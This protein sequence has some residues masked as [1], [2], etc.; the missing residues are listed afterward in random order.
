MADIKD[1]LDRIDSTG[2]LL[3]QD[4]TRENVV[5]IVTGETLS[6]SWW[7]HPKA[8]FV[9][10]ILESV[11]KH[12]DIT[13]SKLIQGKVTFIH[14][15]LWPSIY[16]VGSSKE[17]WQLRTLTQDERRLLKRIE[18]KGMV[19]NPGSTVK[20][21]ER[22]VL[23]HVAQVHS[24][25]GKHITIATSWDNWADKHQIAKVPGK[26]AKRQLVESTIQIK[27]RKEDLPWS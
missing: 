23:V 24:K 7:N 27:G 20:K 14:R 26:E 5:R 1:V 13:L 16:T 9:F 11:A 21:L 4:K 8:G 3:Q 12:P 22:L 18:S 15:R 17:D 25:N 10:S 19:E 2:L 6:T